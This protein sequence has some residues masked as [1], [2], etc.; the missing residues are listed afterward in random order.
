MDTGTA[1][2]AEVGKTGRQNAKSRITTL[3]RLKNKQA[4]TARSVVQPG[5]E[6]KFGVNLC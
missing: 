6:N 4:F 2:C 3:A 1:G 5:G